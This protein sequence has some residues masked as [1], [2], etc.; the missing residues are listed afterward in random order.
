ML[1]LNTEMTTLKSFGCSFIYGDDLSDTFKYKDPWSSYT[2]PAL[3]A[4]DLNI[5]HISYSKSGAGNLQIFQTLCKELANPEPA[6]F[7]I[8][9]TWIDRFDYVT[10]QG[11]NTIRPN[12]TGNI[13]KFY[14]KQLHSQYSDKL[15]NLSLI[16]A[17][18]TLLKQQQRKFIMVCQD[19]LLFETKWHCDSGIQLLQDQIKDSVTWFD[20]QTFLEWAKTN[21]FKISENWHPLEAAH[22]AAFELIKSYR[23]V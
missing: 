17:A 15:T 3:L 16:A 22:H 6:L 23:L 21:N 4:K 20:H 10:A 18:L 5:P 1:S 7:V 19:S 8:G 9:W 13:E 11:W 12:G 2:W 14:Y